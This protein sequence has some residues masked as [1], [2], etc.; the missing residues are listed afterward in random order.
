M[1]TV[2]HGVLVYTLLAAQLRPHLAAPAVQQNWAE[3]FRSSNILNSRCVFSKT[4]LVPFRDTCVKSAHN[5]ILIQYGD[6]N[7]S[8]VQTSYE[9]VQMSSDALVEHCI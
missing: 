3:I 1:C 5:S 4:S 2:V 9:P 8:C 7:M 6:S